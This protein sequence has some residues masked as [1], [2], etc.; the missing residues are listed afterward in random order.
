M[1][2]AYFISKQTIGINKQ[3]NGG[4]FAISGISC[5]EHE[6]TTLF[7]YFDE[8]EPYG[9]YVYGSVLIK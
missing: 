8:L 7:L 5:C 2:R 9:K 1:E 6:K 3:S 4:Y